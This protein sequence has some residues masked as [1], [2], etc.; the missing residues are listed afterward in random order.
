MCVADSAV[1]NLQANEDMI[2]ATRPD[3]SAPALVDGKVLEH[4]FQPRA[5]GV[6]RIGVGQIRVPA[7]VEFTLR[8]GSAIQHQPFDVRVGDVARKLPKLCS[9]GPGFRTE[10][11]AFKLTCWMFWESHPEACCLRTCGH[12]TA[13][14]VVGVRDPEGGRR[15][16]G[17]N[18]LVGGILTILTLSAPI[19]SDYGIGRITRSGGIALGQHPQVGKILVAVFHAIFEEEAVA[20]VVVRHIVLNPHIVGAMYRH[21]AAESVVNRRVLDV[22]PRRIANQMPMDRIPR[23]VLVL[24]HSKE[25]DT[26]DFHGDPAIAITCPPLNDF[27]E[28]AEAWIRI[29]RVSIPTSPRSSTPKVT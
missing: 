24:T 28:S 14:S 16:V 3:S 20:D 21:T 13:V 22:L 15:V 2:L 10:L 23:K 17:R 9:T 12:I 19:D 8:I 1:G 4:C 7:K 27:S 26:G 25:L 29:L 6:G 11:R 18:Q 5:V